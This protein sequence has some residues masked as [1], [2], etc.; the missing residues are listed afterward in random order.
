V[1]TDDC[2]RVGT[3]TLDVPDTLGALNFDL[4]LTAGDL[5]QTNRYKTV[6]TVPPD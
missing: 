3:V 6:I 4:I 5:I 2:V 1:G